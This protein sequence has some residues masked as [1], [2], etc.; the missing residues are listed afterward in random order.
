MRCM[1]EACLARG[2]IKYGFLLSARHLARREEFRA[3]AAKEITPA[4]NGFAR[5]NIRK[6]ARRGYMGLPIPAGMGGPGRRLFNLHPAHRRDI[7]DLRLYRGDPGGAYVGGQF[8]AAL[9]RHRR[10]KAALP[11]R[12]GPAV[13]AGRFRAYRGGGRIRCRR[14]AHDRT[15][16]SGRQ[17]HPERDQ[18]FYYQRRRSR[19]LHRFC[20]DRSVQGQQGR[21][22]LS[23]G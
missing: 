5:E 17:L 16:R 2:E 15:E 3:F 22:R 23:R 11:C 7:A 8:P 4:V 13:P 1:G 18:A 6:A 20:S 21:N 19:S 10:A 14:P 9:F 12:A